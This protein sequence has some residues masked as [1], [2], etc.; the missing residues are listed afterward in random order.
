ML[1]QKSNTQEMELW[2][3]SIPVPKPCAVRSKFKICDA[4]NPGQ[5][6]V[7]DVVKSLCM[8]KDFK[9]EEL[10]AVPF[11]GFTNPIKTFI[12]QFYT[13]A[14]IALFTPLDNFDDLLNSLIA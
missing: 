5:I 3:H 11:K 13:Y 9:F 4:S 6:L 10:E 8:G 1:A 14:C 2:L 7:S 12:V